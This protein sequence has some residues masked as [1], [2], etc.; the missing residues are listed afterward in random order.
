M[1]TRHSVRVSRYLSLGPEK[2]IGIPGQPQPHYYFPRPLS[3]LLPAFFRAGFVLDGLE[4]PAFGAVEAARPLTW[5]S[6]AEIPPVLVV[7]MRLLSLE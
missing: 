3:S 1:Q 6:L 7:R 4:E 5:A 2:G